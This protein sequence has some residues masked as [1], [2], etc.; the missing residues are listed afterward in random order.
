MLKR[1]S[2][3]RR[4]AFML[5]EFDVND[6]SLKQMNQSLDHEWGP[7]LIRGNTI[8]DGL[9]RVEIAEFAGITHVEAINL[10]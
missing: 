7:I 5:R 10:E 1:I 9:R 4:S 2:A 3:L 8:I 6:L